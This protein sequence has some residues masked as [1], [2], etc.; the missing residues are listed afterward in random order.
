MR[1]P[2]TG[3]LIAAVPLFLALQV[4]PAAG[5]APAG[6]PKPAGG[7]V[8]LEPG[9]LKDLAWRPV[10]PANMGGRVSDFAVVEKRPAT[11][12]MSLGTGGAFK[13]ANLGTTWSAVFEKEAVASVGAIAVWQKN[14][15]VVWAGTGEANSRNSSSWG[16]GVYRSLDGGSKWEH[17]GLEATHCIARV[18]V[19]PGDSNTVYV[20]AL[21]RLWGENAERGVF[22]TT[23]GGKH[24]SHV[25][26][27]DARTGACDLV[28][29]PSNPSVLYAAMYARRRTPWSYSGGGKTGGI[30]RTT[31]AGRTWTRLTNGLPAEAGRIGLDVYRKN[32]KTVMAVVESD[33]GGH[34]S[35]FESKSRAGGVFRST[36]GGEHW[37]RLSPYAPRPFYFSQLRVQPD[38]SSRVYLLGTDLWI[39]DD[40]GR[41]F[42]AGG[43]RN[44]H[45]DC[46]AMW[47]DPANGDHV[48]LGTDGGLFMSHD[49]ARTWNFIN[50][51][52][53]GEFYNVAVDNRDPYWIYGG[54]Q[55]NQTWGGPSKT[56][57]EPEPFIGDQEHNGILNDHWFCLG[58]GDGFHVAVD[59][60]DPD[61]VYYESQGAELQ[62]L[63]LKTGKERRLKPSNKEGEPVFRFNWNSPFM[64][65]PHDPSVLWL[66][67]NHL[68]RL[69][70]RG[71]RWEMASPDLTTRDP[72][73]MATGGSA[74]ETHCTIVTLA[75]S[76]LAKGM[77]WA[78]TDDGQLW[79]TRDGGAHWND[80]TANLKGVPP[81]LYMSRVEA[82][83]HDA[84]TAYLAID[85]HRT[86]VFEPYLLATR[87]GGKSWTSIL[88]D[89]PRS[90]PVIVVREDLSNPNLLFAGTEFGIWMTLDGGRHWV[91]LKEGLPTVAVDDIVIHPRERDLVIG[92]H[93]RS[94]YVLDDITPCERWTAGV[95]ADPVTFFAPRP[96]TAYLH[97]TIGGVWGQRMF[98]AKNPP[99]GATFNYFVR[100]W[101]GEGVTIVVADSAGRTI[102]NLS[103]PGTPGLHRAVWDL[104]RDPKERIGRPEW[105][106][107]PEFVKPGKYTVSL[108]YGKEK[109]VKQTLEVKVADGVADPGF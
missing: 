33:L 50:N 88:G 75:E 30:F 53:I 51:L 23:D 16:N 11:F 19:D 85:G 77:V 99:F 2:A 101:T 63:S 13:T 73:K 17:L 6:K 21:G 70:E 94:I 69:V 83:H 106:N 49:R 97:R 48:L 96:A 43:A 9:L 7:V 87:D 12:F 35:E 78:G 29:D 62:R 74:A 89:L 5:A 56:R 82:S 24:W 64:I 47:V 34:L 109:P 58:G 91:K 32:P 37:E 10:G 36:D 95:L 71:D 90:A 98:S 80:L 107:Q 45:P 61:I 15:D 31:D 92:T 52:A 60:T 81:G 104:E 79:V 22:K 105:S 4:A 39:S 108:T 8:A 59:P 3:S 76:P 40:G 27:V 44:L 72:N 1:R 38:D 65:S 14:P 26:E 57:F 68:F 18:V 100:A 20:A 103:G 86:N 55:D 67:G 28:M 41:T 66:G 42:R 84:N 25:L 93:G 102:R 54:L 46:H